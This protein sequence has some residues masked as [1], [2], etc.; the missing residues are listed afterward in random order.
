MRVPASIVALRQGKK[1][2]DE[3]RAARQGDRNRQQGE[4][5]EP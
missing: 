2:D 5:T 3:R 1:G 4:V